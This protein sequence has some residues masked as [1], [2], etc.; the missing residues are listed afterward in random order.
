MFDRVAEWVAGVW[1][2]AWWFAFCLGFVG[3]WLIW[4]AVGSKWTDDIWHL[5]LNS[6]TTALTFLGLFLLHNTQHRFEQRTE[7][8][9][10][11]IT[12]AVCPSDPV[13]EE[14][15]NGG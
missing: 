10:E 1:S 4:G 11:R 7:A 2:S 14:G 8:R 15:L 12:K 3:S 5:A 13:E 9:L 6:P